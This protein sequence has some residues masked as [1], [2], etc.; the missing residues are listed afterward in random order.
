MD[1]YCIHI[2]VP[3]VNNVQEVLPKAFKMNE[4]M[5][6][7]LSKASLQYPGSLKDKEESALIKSNVRTQTRQIS[8]L[9][10]SEMSAEFSRFE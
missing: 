5:D 6:A 8:T 10:S 9:H 3:V 1:A 4:W 2:I 7:C